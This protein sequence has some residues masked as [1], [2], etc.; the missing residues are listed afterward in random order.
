MRFL[1]M[2]TNSLLAGALGAA[3]LTVLVLQLNPQIPLLSATVWRWYLTLGALYGLH[4]AVLFY[5][6]M[7]V[8]EF[9]A[10]DGLSPGWASV[11][12]LAWM[13]AAAA[14]VAAALMWLNVRGFGAA[15]S[16]IAARRMTTGAIAPSAAAGVLL[17]IAIAHYSFG[18]RGSRV[19]AS[20]FVIAAFASLA[21]PLAARGPAVDPPAPLAPQPGTDGGSST[22]SGQAPSTSSGQGIGPRVSMVLLDG[23]SLDYVL[24]RVAEGRLPAFARVIEKGALMDLAT[25]RPTQPD[26]VWAA[27]ATGMYP[28][29][30]GVRSA[31][32][33]YAR[34]DHRPVDLLP[35]HCFSHVLVHLGF[36]R[37]ELNVSTAWRARPLWSIVA[38]AGLPVGVVR[39]PLTYPAAAVGGFLVSDRFHQVVGSIAAFDR[40]AYPPEI[41][42]VLSAAFSDPLFPAE[43]QPAAAGLDAGASPEASAMQRDRLYSRA[44]RELA[45]QMDPRLVALRYDGLD[46]VGHYYLRYTRPR[47]FRDVPEEERRRFSQ[48]L[49]RY[50]AFI[51]SEIG[52]VLDTMAQGDLLV[53][54]SG[55]GMEPLNPVKQAIGRLLG[56]PD[57]SGTHERAPDGFL[58][59]YGAA[60]EPGRRERGS[61][62]DVAPTLLYFLGLPVARDMDGY[63][64]ADLFTR[65]FKAERPIVFIPSYSR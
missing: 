56:D 53:I 6:V 32:S 14:A 58:L 18:R 13:A 30:N 40:A 21:L 11:R 54:V 50:Y 55:F 62:V 52:A 61:I 49:D 19:G 59:A 10:L 20:L 25:I 8:R 38:A 34:D 41:L 47:T 27:V 12:L 4:L 16:E 65:D 31:A 29:K 45:A 17:G 33:Y 51:D 48:V 46:V 1:R 42:P 22:G 9:F 3:Y 57:F 15:L 36:V 64:R 44:M 5:V 35:D 37:E 43:A 7:V 2:L 26:P 23:A 28:S 39:W 24:P 63:A 60:A